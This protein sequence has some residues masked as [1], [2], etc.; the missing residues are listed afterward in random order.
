MKGN[1]T[2]DRQNERDIRMTM[3]VNATAPMLVA[4]A[5]I[6]DMMARNS[7]HIC[8]IASAAGMLGVPKLSVY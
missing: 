6:P 3:D 5:M 1:A 2:F 7:G 8:N 4:L